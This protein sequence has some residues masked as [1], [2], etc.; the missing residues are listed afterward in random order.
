MVRTVHFNNESLPL[1][2]AGCDNQVVRPAMTHL[3]RDAALRKPGQRKASMGED[4]GRAGLAAAR[5]TGCSADDL[6]PTSESL[7]AQAGQSF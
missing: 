4:K 6:E 5:L 2:P 3:R 7:G 1:P